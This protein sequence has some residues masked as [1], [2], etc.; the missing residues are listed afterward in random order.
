MKQDRARN[1]IAALCLAALLL[2][3]PSTALAAGTVSYEGKTEGIVFTRGGEAV[4]ELFA[5]FENVMPGDSLEE[6]VTLRNNSPDSLGVRVY[7][8]A[9]GPA[10]GADFLSQLT[11]TVSAGAQQLSQAAANQTGAL[12]DWVQIAGLDPGEEQTLTLKL[13]VPV[14]MGN[15][16]QAAAASLRWSFRVEEL[17]PKPSPSPT[18]TASPKPSPSPTTTPGKGPKTGDESQPWLYAGLAAVSAAGMF[19]LLVLLRS[20]KRRD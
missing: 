19:S 9:L 15:E 12:G 8:K 13:E 4:T 7:L 20:K 5:G 16:F 18:P 1:W 11:I 10:S 17:D 14:T 2:C 3:M 6:T